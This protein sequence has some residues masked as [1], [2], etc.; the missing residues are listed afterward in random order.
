M[1]LFWWK[2]TS[3]LVEPFTSSFYSE[4]KS[5]RVE[6]EGS[7]FIWNFD[8]CHTAFPRRQCWFRL[9]SEPP[10]ISHPL[11]FSWSSDNANTRNRRPLTGWIASSCLCW[12]FLIVSL[13]ACISH[14]HTLPSVLPLSWI[15]SWVC[16]MV[17]DG[18]VFLTV[19]MH[20]LPLFRHVDAVVWEG[21]AKLR[22]PKHLGLPF[23]LQAA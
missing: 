4:D 14:F 16:Q 1:L 10:H 22:A 21:W 12:Y 7:R 13:G 6:D 19:Y 20:S 5:F 9:A 8:T 17:F 3:V 18:T 15:L 2:V 23:Y 11:N